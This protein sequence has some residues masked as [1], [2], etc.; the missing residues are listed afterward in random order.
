MG[1]FARALEAAQHDD[2]RRLGGETHAAVPA[3]HQLSQLLV[4][5]FD[6]LLGGRER[7]EHFL[8][9][10]ALGHIRDKRLDHFEVHVRRKQRQLDFPHNGLDVGLCELAPALQAP[11]YIV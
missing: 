9:H 10:G 2:R 7:F 3:A 1:R 11:E 4:D 5:D 8:A 6:N